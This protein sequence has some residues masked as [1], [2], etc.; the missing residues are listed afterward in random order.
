MR[1]L[2]LALLWLAPTAA[3]AAPNGAIPSILA[4]NESDTD[5]WASNVGTP[6]TGERDLYLWFLNFVPD[7]VT[8]SFQG[9]FEVV[10]IA[11][12]PGWTNTGTLLSPRLASSLGCSGG[13]ETRLARVRVRDPTGSGGRTCFWESDLDSKMCFDSCWG[14]YYVIGEAMGYRTDA[15]SYCDQIYSPECEPLAVEPASWGRAKVR[16]R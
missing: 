16:Y 7:T 2:L 14:S 8:F 6:F 1:S 4:L 5:G 11:P 10:E 15:G 13:P 3:M 9:T 12:E